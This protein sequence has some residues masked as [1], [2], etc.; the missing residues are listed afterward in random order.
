MI[1]RN[2]ASAPSDGR[3]GPL[4]KSR[5]PIAT[6]ALMIAALVAILLLP[7]WAETGELRSIWLFVVPVLL[8]LIGAVVALKTGHRWWAAF[9]AVWGFVLIQLLVVT[10]T[11]IS[12]S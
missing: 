3:G 10:I 7:D 8:G 9:S 12:G 1:G 11:L 6:W 4:P 2:G 5:R